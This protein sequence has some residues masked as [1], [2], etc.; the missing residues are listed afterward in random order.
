MKFVSNKKQNNQR[1]FFNAVFLYETYVFYSVSYK[2]KEC[3][4]DIL[5]DLIYLFI[6]L[7]I[8]EFLSRI[9]SSVLK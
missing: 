1:F 4:D 3:I 7:F 8:Y 2:K 5:I 9:A 6:Y